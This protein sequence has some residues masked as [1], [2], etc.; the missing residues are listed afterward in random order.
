MDGGN[1]KLEV[2]KKPMGQTYYTLMH[3]IILLLK[4]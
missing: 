1:A 3:I 2:D 4:F